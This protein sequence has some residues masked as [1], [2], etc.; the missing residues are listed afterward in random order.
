MCC[1]ISPSVHLSLSPT[2]YPESLPS[3]R[4]QSVCVCVF[5]CDDVLTAALYMCV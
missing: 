5:V 4:E 2:R 1:H 3:A